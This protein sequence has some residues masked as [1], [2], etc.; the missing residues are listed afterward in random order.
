MSKLDEQKEH[1]G[2][3]KVYL[4]FILVVILSL[5]TGLVNMYLTGKYGILFYTGSFIILLAMMLFITTA[6]AIHKTISS[7]KDL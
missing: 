3:L 6:R 4:G 1:I 7:L 2:I 5:G